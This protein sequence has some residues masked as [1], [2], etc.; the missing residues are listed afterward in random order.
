MHEVG[1]GLTSHGCLARV[2]AAVES[3]RKRPAAEAAAGADTRGSTVKQSKLF[4]VL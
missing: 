3:G 2:L 1:P 4:E